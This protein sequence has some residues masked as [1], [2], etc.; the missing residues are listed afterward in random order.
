MQPVPVLAGTTLAA[1]MLVLVLLY[2]EQTQISDSSHSL[3]TEVAAGED[4]GRGDQGFTGVS[5]SQP[6]FAVEIRRPQGAPLVELATDDPFGRPARVACSTCHSIRDPNYENTHWS[7]L[8]EFHQGLRVEHGKLVCYACHNPDHADTLKSADGR[9]IPYTEVMTLCSQCHG[10][11]ATAY[12][13]GAHGGM[14]GYWDLTRGPQQKN[15]CVDCHDPHRPNYPKMIVTFKPQDRF[16][17]GEAVHDDH[18]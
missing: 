8:D 7:S 4:D 11:Q 2:P 15:N 3:E 13:H 6:L 18:E 14:N 12:A 5:A 17:D 1:V 9:Q 10:P 16:L